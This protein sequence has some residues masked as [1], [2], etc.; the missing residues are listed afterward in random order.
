MSANSLQ[1]TADCAVSK[2]IAS[3]RRRESIRIDFA[4]TSKKAH[5]AAGAGRFNASSAPTHDDN[6]SIWTRP[7]NDIRS[8]AL[9]P[10]TARDLNFL[11][12]YYRSIQSLECLSV[13]IKWVH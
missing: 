9:V 2:I 4:I 7:L 3:I 5:L 8:T 6:L 1:Q 12:L 10:Y 13:N 11:E